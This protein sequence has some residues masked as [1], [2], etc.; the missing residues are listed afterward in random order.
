MHNR[1]HIICYNEYDLVTW[2]QVIS[3]RDTIQSSYVLLNTFGIS[4]RERERGVF[5]WINS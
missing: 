1:M 5:I 4:W 3:V 2:L